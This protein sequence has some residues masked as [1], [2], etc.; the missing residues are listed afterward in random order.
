MLLCVY[1]MVAFLQINFVDPVEEAFPSKIV[2]LCSKGAS[3]DYSGLQ[4]RGL[5]KVFRFS[6]SAFLE[7]QC[8]GGMDNYI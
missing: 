3:Y 2:R 4:Q 1:V 6:F 7:L 5:T 8:L